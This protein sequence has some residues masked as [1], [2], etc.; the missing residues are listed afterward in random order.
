MATIG[1]ARVSTS[2]QCINLQL[3]ALEKAECDHVFRDNGVSA[4]IRKRPGFM[5]AM[6]A[7][8][9]GDQFVVWKMDRAFRSVLHASAMLEEFMLGGIKLVCLTEPLDIR[10]PHDRCMYHV[11]SAFSELER[12]VIS[13][14]TIAGLEAARRRGVRLGRPPK[15]SQD[16]KQLVRNLWAKDPA[17]T[18]RI[19]S[20]RFGV[21]PRT[22]TR[23]L[24]HRS[25]RHGH[26]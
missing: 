8:D 26:E 19:L 14:R 10:D 7:L 4:K 9:S 25:E 23:A 3:D 13:E 15:L 12:E 17:L 22:I 21:S 20:T 2:D 6:N 5:A 18:P 1:Y 16:Q 24:R 11:K